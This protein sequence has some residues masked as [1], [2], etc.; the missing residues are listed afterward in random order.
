[1]DIRYIL[2]LLIKFLL[3]YVITI[4]II[5][6]IVNIVLSSSKDNRLINN[7]IGFYGLFM[8]MGDRDVLNLSIIIL[9]YFF[10]IFSL[11]NSISITSIHLYI[12]ILLTI[13]YSISSLSIKNLL[14]GLFSSFGV[15]IGLFLTKT[16]T[17]YLIDV[18]YLWYVYYGRILL[19]IFLLI[20]ASFFF[21]KE[22]NETVLNSKYI[23]RIRSES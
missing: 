13:I 12:L 21:I 20:Y 7:K 17:N 18:Y 2:N 11:F 19:V 15:Y 10:I 3:F 4:L 14:L 16:L 23:R 8:Q 5:M 9:R 1:M 6:I 22:V